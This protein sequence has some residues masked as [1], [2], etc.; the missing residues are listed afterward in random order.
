M[1]RRVKDRVDKPE[2][3]D[4]DAEKRD[5]TPPAARAAILLCLAEFA[6]VRHGSASLRKIDSRRTVHA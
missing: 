1:N 2:R 4:A 6:I 3:N 5:V